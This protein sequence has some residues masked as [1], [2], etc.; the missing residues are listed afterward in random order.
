MLLTVLSRIKN[1]GD[2]LKDGSVRFIAVDIKDEQLFEGIGD[3][4]LSDP[5]SWKKLIQGTNADDRPYLQQIY[6]GLKQTARKAVPGFRNV[7]LY[8]IR[9]SSSMWYDLGRKG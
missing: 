9:N 1:F 2:G 8:N 4:R 3:T 7:F 5:D 6:D